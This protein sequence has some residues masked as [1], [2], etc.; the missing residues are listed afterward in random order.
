[1][2]ESEVYKI[3]CFAVQRHRAITGHRWP[4]ALSQLRRHLAGRVEWCPGQI[5]LA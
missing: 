3:E 5:R 4:A 2:T 1:M